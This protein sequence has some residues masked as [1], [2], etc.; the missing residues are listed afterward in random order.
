M[1]ALTFVDHNQHRDNP[2]PITIQGKDLR[3]IYDRIWDGTTVIAP[4]VN[5]IAP[6]GS[7]DGWL[8]EGGLFSDVN[9]WEVK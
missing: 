6:D 8:I 5:G 3:L 7:G 9:L 4:Y 1:T 2:A